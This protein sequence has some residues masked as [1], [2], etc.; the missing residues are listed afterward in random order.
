[1]KFTKYTWIAGLLLLNSISLSA[2]VN[3]DFSDGDF[4]NSPVWSGDSDEFEVDAMQELHLIAPANEGESYLSTPSISINNAQWDIHVRMDFNPSSSNRSYIY[5]TSD[6][7]DLEGELNGYFVMI[8]NTADEISLYRQ[9]G[10][11]TIKII[12]GTDDLVDVDPV[13]VAVRVTR[14]DQGNWELSAD[15]GLTGSFTSQGNVLDDTYTSSSYF[16]VRCDYTSTRSELFWF[17]DIVVTGDGVIDDVLPELNDVVAL[18]ENT[19]ELQFSEALD[20]SSAENVNNYTL[21]P[22]TLPVSASA[23]GA[24]VVLEFLDPFP[25]NQELSIEVS[26]VMDPAGNTLVTTTVEFMYVVIGIGLERS[27]VINE[28]MADPNPSLGLPEAEYIELYNP[29]DSAY[30]LSDWNLQN[31]ADDEFLENYIL[32]PGEYV[33][34]CDDGFQSAFEGYGATLAVSTLTAL[35]NTGDDLRLYNANGMLIDSV[36]YDISWYGGEPFDDGGYSLERVNPT[37]PCDNPTNWIPS[38]AVPGGTPGTENSLFI[39]ADTES[40]QLIHIEVIGENLIIL[41]F[42]EGMDELS[43]ITGSYSIPGINSLVP[44][45]ITDITQ[46][47]LLAEPGFVGGESYALTV[48][49]VQDCSGNTIETEIIEFF[50]SPQAAEGDLIINEIMADPTPA[51]GLPEAEYLE[52]YNRSGFTFDLEN[53]VL[54]N[55][56]TDM[57]LGEFVIAPGEYVILCDEDESDAFTTSGSVLAIPSFSSLNNGGDDLYL[58]DPEGVTIDEVAYSSAW[59][60]DPLRDDGGYS[61]ERINPDRPCSDGNNWRAST[62][63]QG[64]TPGSANSVLD[65]SPDETAPSPVSLLINGTQQL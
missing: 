2:Q 9:D 20:P 6:Q 3:D 56:T 40:P 44:Q 65:L 51:I 36:N 14:D 24:T 34:I 42:N 62:A 8:G 25:E 60:N 22:S 26:G 55:T 21:L 41:Q 48:D 5:L 17:D 53:W 32:L 4:T 23:D 47:A 18:D 12:D 31:S 35:S 43:L 10:S 28:L 58:I 63:V 45:P 37:L 13:E 38:Q 52:L 46:V 33:I 7:P 1:M 16:G 59:Y 27:V 39:P 57:I 11:S 49:D 19:L 15:V 61:L 29:S 54:R 30:D 50:I 64:G